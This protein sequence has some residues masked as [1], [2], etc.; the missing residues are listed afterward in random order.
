MQDKSKPTR[1]PMIW[2]RVK[3][4]RTKLCTVAHFV[5][6][7]I[8]K[9]SEESRKQTFSVQPLCMYAL[10]FIPLYKQEFYKCYSLSPS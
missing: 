9:I 5:R 3:V 7:E 8:L 2:L 10:S 1:V 4:N 6:N